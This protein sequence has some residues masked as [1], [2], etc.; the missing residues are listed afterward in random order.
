MERLPRQHGD[1][2]ERGADCKRAAATEKFA[3]LIGVRTG[4]DVVV[5]RRQSQQLVANAPPRPQRLMP[6][7]PQLADDVESEFA[8]GRLFVHRF[9]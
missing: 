1:H 7:R 9:P 2:A 6:R 4:G 8:L 3:D 5:L